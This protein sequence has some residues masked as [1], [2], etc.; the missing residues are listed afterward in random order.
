LARI[1]FREL[2]SEEKSS[3]THLCGRCETLQ[4][5]GEL[6]HCIPTE[7]WNAAKAAMR[8]QNPMPAP[9]SRQPLQATET[10]AETP[11]EEDETEADEA[12]ETQIDTR[13]TYSP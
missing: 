8:A 5:R 2:T 1:E 12:R 13:R 6:H 4:K 10:P 3:G 11:S 9:S 7:R